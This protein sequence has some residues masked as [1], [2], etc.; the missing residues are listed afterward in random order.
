ML[1]CDEKLYLDVRTFTDFG[2]IPLG[3]PRVDDKPYGDLDTS[4]FAYTP[5][6][7]GSINMVRAYYRWQI[8]TDLIRPYITN[9]RPDD[10]SMPSDYLIVGTAA[11]QNEAY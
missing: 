8:I 1:D 5:G 4:N 7:P 3:I 10:G 6:G 2:D 11:F 9:I